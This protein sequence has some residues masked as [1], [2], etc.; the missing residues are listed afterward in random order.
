[1]IK[2]WNINAPQ[3]RIPYAIFHKIYSFCTPFE[4]ALAFKISLDLLE[5]LWSY[6]GFKLTGLVIPKFSAPLEAKL[7]ARPQKF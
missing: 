3:G 2:T 5:A 4:D 7:C 1:M 6:G